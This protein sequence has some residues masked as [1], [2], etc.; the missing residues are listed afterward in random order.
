[1]SNVKMFTKHATVYGLIVF[2]AEVWADISQGRGRVTAFAYKASS[3]DFWEH[4]FPV[5]LRVWMT[6]VM[7]Q[8]ANI[9][10]WP[11]LRLRPATLGGKT[12]WR[13]GR[14]GSLESLLGNI[15]R[16]LQA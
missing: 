16:E 10:V 8:G 4:I 7:K 6:S 11:L 3:F 2:D 14:R 13:R 12:N 15:R 5:I 9:V 1:V